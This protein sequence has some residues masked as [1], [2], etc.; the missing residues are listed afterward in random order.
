M[1][2]KQNVVGW[3]RNTVKFP[4]YAMGAALLASGLAMAQGGPLVL[5]RAGRTIALEPYAPNIL[6][7]TLSIDRAAATGAPGY[8]FV[9]KPSAEG[10][11]HERDAEGYD[12]YRSAR[13][14]VRLAPENLP[15]DKRPQP[16]PLDPLNLELRHQYFGGGGGNG[17][18][19]GGRGPHNDALLVSTAEGKMLLH[20]RTWMM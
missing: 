15:K 13:M 18:N 1:M 5:E 12:V 2:E 10:W 17:P 20:M 4:A 19:D 7:V 9:A 14:V 16:M 6:R 3:F 8:G 11:T